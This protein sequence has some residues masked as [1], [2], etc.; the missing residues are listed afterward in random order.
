MR[1]IILT[2]LAVAMTTAVWADGPLATVGTA[3]IDRAT[4]EKHIKAKLLEIENERYEAMK[5]GLDELVS[6]SL[7][8]QEAKARNITV[9]ALVKAEVTDKITAA[10][11]D[12]IK[13]VYDENKEALQNAPLDSVKG[14]IVDYLKAQRSG[15]RQQAFVDELKKKYPTK[16]SL[17]APKIEVGTGGRPVLGPA[18][19]PIT[20]IEFSDYECP[21]CKRAEPA[22]EQVFSTYKDK[23]KFVYRHYPLPFHQNARP[24]SIAALCAN[25]QGKYWEY[26]KKVFAS[27]SLAVDAL[28]Q[29]AKD[30]NLDMTK[31]AAC[32]KDP[33]VSKMIDKD[34]EDGQAVGVNGTPAFFVNGRMLS[35]AQPFEKFKELINQALAEGGA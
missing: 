29:I 31:F 9:E 12:E 1:R 13:K 17:S 19:A 6:E 18:N 8:T 11:D 21:F 26:H 15:T 22:L 16:I 28:N 14:K 20:I 34:L 23:V 30:L 32:M 5:D 7:M 2:T 27:P 4:V 10:T 35:G 33:E 25:P 3:T 24:A